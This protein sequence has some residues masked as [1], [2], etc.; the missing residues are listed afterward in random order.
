[1]GQFI[2]LTELSIINR[3]YKRSTYVSHFTTK[4]AMQSWESKQRRLRTANKFGISDPWYNLDTY[5]LISST[6]DY[7]E[8]F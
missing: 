4:F 7:L 5:C 1:M 6:N 2:V 3:A 8:G